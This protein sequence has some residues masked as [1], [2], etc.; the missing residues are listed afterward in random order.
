MT[1]SPPAELPAALPAGPIAARLSAM[2]WNRFHTV[3]VL[4]FGMGWA[5]DAFE[6]TLIGNVL[7]ALR[8]RFQLG[9]DAMSLILGAWFAGLMLGAAG[10][11]Y[12]AD[13]Y[14]RRRIF[15]ASLVLYG[16]ATLAAALAPNLAAL[17]LLRLLAGIGVGAEYSAINAAIA[18]LVPSRSRGRAAALVLN[19]WPIGSL[20]A[21]LLSWLVLSALPPDLGWRVVF[22][23][24]G[25]IALSSAWFRRHLPESPRWLESGGRDA[26]ALAIVAGIEAGMT[27]LP[28]PEPAPIGQRM[29]REGAGVM[30]LL[31][32]CPARLALGAVLDFAEASGYYGLFAFLPLVVLPALHLA[33]ARLPLFYLAGSVGALCGGLVASVLLDRWGRC[34]TVSLFYLATAL[35]TVG[36]AFATDLGAGVLMLGF[37]LVNLLATGS[38]IAAYPTFSEL[39]PTPLRASGIGASVAVGRIGAMIS[40]FLVGTLGARS[41]P[42][43]LLLLAGFWLLGAATMAV[44]RWTGG[45]EA[46]GLPLERIA[47]QEAAFHA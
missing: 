28:V 8:E 36:L 19:F 47:P 35:G 38:W 3:I 30:T 12:L 26:E 29:R 41:M 44:W 18:E 46:S 1:L 42:A 43:A 32:R 20:V 16:V 17:L 24:G 39:F 14:G 31:R 7:G 33:P 40:P 2:Q 4:L 45:I 6:V 23:F 21:A 25:V 9:A 34:A 11:G 37:A 13:R 27:S 5:M 22:G 10:F 15:L